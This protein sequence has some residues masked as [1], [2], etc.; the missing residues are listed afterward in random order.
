M[1]IAEAKKY[2]KRGDRAELS[3]NI[4]CHRNMIRLVINGEVESPS[5]K[6]AIIKLG[7][8]R[9]KELNDRV[10]RMRKSLNHK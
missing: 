8:L 9:Q 4:D 10:N 6:E 5:I 7:Q 2:L 3:R 1:T